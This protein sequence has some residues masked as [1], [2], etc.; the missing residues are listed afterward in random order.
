MKTVISSI[1]VASVVSA[2]CAIAAPESVPDPQRP[3]NILLLFVDDL[4]YAD[5][6]FRGS[7]IDTPSLDRLATEGMELR[8]FY[9]TPICSPTRAALMTGRDPIRLGVVYGVLLPW[10]SGGVHM[11]EHFMPQS[12]KAAGYQT[13]MF[14][15]WHLGHS[16]QQLTPNARGFDEFYGHLHTEVGYFPPFANVGGKDFQHNGRSIDDEGYETFLLADRASE[17]IRS[18]DRE[19]PF[20]LY[21]PFLAPHEPLQA[22]DQ[23]VDKYADMK[24]RREMNWCCGGGGGVSAIER[25]EEL[26]LKVFKRKTAQLE[27]LNVDKLVTA[28]ANCRLVMEEG[29]EEYKLEIPIVGLTEMIAEHLVEDKA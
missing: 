19:R 23:L 5:P 15:K 4:G 29:L 21:M 3:P 28:C 10:D 8:R 2:R 26:R 13:A 1:V 16:Q 22:P 17:W 24:D 12:F 25:A 11:S 7:G 9:T 18:R 20:F 27:E 14:G 6:G